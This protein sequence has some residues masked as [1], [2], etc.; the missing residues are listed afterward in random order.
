[1]KT[2]AKIKPAL[3]QLALAF[4]AHT[5]ASCVLVAEIEK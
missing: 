3:R 5:N 2:R 4:H 1:M